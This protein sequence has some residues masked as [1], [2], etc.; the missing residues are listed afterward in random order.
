MERSEIVTVVDSDSSCS[1]SVHVDKNVHV[2]DCRA[3][4]AIAAHYART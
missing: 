4:L 2:D 3:L 1:A